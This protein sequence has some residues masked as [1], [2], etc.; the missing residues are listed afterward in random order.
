[1]RSQP[2]A[3]RW[4]HGFTLIELMVVVAVIAILASI[5]YPTYM[6][7][8]QKTRRNLATGCLT[9]FAQWMERNYTTCLKYNKTGVSCTTDVTTASFTSSCKT[10]LANYYDFSFASSPALSANEYVL[11][12]VPKSGSPQAADSCGTL[13]LNQSGVKGA[14]AT[15][16]WRK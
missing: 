11:Q 7:S 10:E 3:L 1:M 2:Y 5:S 9:E 16:C 14:G 13:T 6:S 15:D 8:V 12:A 4:Q